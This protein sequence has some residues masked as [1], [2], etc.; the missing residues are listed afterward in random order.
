V[1]TGS[2][3]VCL[4][5]DWDGETMWCGP[6]KPESPSA[7]SRGRY[8]ARVAVPRIEQMLDDYGIKSTFF[9]PGHTA[10]L[11]PELVR[12]LYDKGHEI[13]HHNYYHEAAVSLTLD[14]ER[15]IV[16]RSSAVLAGITGERPVGY[17]CPSWLTSIHTMDLLSEYGFLYDSSMM[18]EE[19]PYIFEPA[20]GRPEM[21]E[22]PV[23]WELDD[24][25]Y[26][27]FNFSPAYRAGMSSPDKVFG[28]WKTEFLAAYDTHHFFNL[29][30]HPQISGHSHRLLMVR[31]LIEF[32]RSKP[33]VRF[34]RCRDAASLVLGSKG[35]LGPQV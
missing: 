25:P 24:A 35:R 34:M 17:R 29:T 30:M 8:A 9:V 26:F 16:E 13:G 32:M 4:S 18:D 1:E 11:H 5:F 31:E 27:L 28:I 22:L 20:P 10:S 12:R 23:A 19:A 7:E 6:G 14:E 33:N 3:I 2:C 21:V 15:A